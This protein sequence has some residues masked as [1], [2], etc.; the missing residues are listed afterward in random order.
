MSELRLVHYGQLESLRRQQSDEESELRQ[1]YEHDIENLQSRFDS[2]SRNLDAGFH[3]FVNKDL[4]SDSL[5]FSEIL[6]R[7]DAMDKL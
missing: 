7:F 3:H 2:F 6:T 5:M 1:A 4:S